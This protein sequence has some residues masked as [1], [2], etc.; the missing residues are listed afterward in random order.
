MVASALKRWGYEVVEA[1]D[2]AEAYD[3]LQADDAPPLAI[4][5]WVMPGLTGVDVC[6]RVRATPGP[7]YSYLLLLT[8]RDGTEHLVE[9][10]EAG[11]DDYVTKP[12]QAEE[13]RA[14]VRAGQRLLDLQHQLLEA[15]AR[16][17]EQ[18]SRDGLTGLWNRRAIL[19]YY[20]L[21]IARA[22]RDEQPIS[23]V[24]MDIDRFKKINDTYGHLAGDTVL[25]EVARRLVAAIRPYDGF[26]RYGGEEFVGILPGCELSGAI[27]V[28]ERLRQIMREEPIETSEDSLSI[29][30]SFGV[31]SARFPSSR[32]PEEL[33]RAADD[34]L[35]AAKRNGRDRVETHL[36]VSAPPL[37]A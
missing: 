21:H 15:Q 37:T 28:A 14:R 29:T 12:F 35:Y 32:T 33:L 3:M 5:D 17:R 26:G 2:G 6:R 11:A 13:L 22:E 7:S 36:P 16:L 20:E 18:A 9:G 30:M 25:K 4:L 31:A 34:A 19:E 8:S 10:M 24:L 23:V 27:A 1:R